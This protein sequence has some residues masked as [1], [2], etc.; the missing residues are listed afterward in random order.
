MYSITQDQLLLN[1]N[2][3]GLDD[4]QCVM[5]IFR[6]MVGD[7]SMW[8]VG[9]IFMKTHYIVYDMSNYDEKDPDNSKL[10]VG[11]SRKNNETLAIS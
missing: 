8:T 4:T 1:G 5:P 7:Q 2:I 10:Q 9:S 6:S 11:I 3:F